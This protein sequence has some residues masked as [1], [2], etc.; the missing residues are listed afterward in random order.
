[1]INPDYLWTFFDVQ[2]GKQFVF[3]VYTSSS[4]EKDKFEYVFYSHRI[5]YQHF[6]G[7]LKIWLGNNWDKWNEDQP[8]WFTACAIAS[9]PP[10]MLPETALRSMGGVLGR[11]L[12]IDE[13][14][15]DEKKPKKD[16]GR[17][18]TD[19]KIVPPGDGNPFDVAAVG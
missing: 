17:R 12:S 14:Q 19:L 11:R 3:E 13:M 7:E 16:R 10:D 5:Y 8:D 18:G 6:K 9:V 2:T 15:K 1:M 4:A